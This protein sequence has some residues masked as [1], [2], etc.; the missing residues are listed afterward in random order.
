MNVLVFI[1]TSLRDYER[2]LFYHFILHHIGD[3]YVCA[4]HSEKHNSDYN[5][6]KSTLRENIVDDDFSR[7][8]SLSSFARVS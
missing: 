1:M 7:L 5:N 8:Y 4:Q 6:N 2:N 3:G